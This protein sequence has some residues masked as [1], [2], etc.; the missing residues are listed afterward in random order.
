[1]RGGGGGDGKS[2]PAEGDVPSPGR[3]PSANLTDFLSSFSPDIG[4]SLL[5]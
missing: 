3:T 4:F 2:S 5:K 1:L